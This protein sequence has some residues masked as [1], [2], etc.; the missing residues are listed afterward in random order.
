MVIATINIHSALPFPAS[1]REVLY[2]D[3]MGT[4]KWLC[5]TVPQIYWKKYWILAILNVTTVVLRKRLFVTARIQ[6]P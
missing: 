2:A 6:S 5:K 3:Y 4:R 1:L